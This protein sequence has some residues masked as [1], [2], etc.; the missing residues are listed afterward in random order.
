MAK[1]LEKLQK[2]IIQKQEL[3]NNAKEIL[4][5]E[6]IGID[7]VIDEIID[8]LSSWFL[9]PDL[10]EKPIV[11]NLW[12]L[13]GV[14]KSALVNRL[15]PLL[16]LE[17]K[18]YRFDLGDSDNKDLAVKRQLE[19]IY[20]NVNGYPIMIALDEFQHARTIDEAGKEIDK[21]ASRIVW[22]L[23]DSG[24]FQISRCNHQFA[25]LF[26]LAIKLRYF[27]RIGV[28]VSKGK[29]TSKKEYFIKEMEL[30]QEYERFH[31]VEVKLDMNN[32]FFVPTSFHDDLYSLAKE[33]FDSPFDVKTG[34]SKL[35]GYETLQYLDN[36]FQFANSPKTVDCSKAL[37][38]VLGNLD[39]AYTMSHVYI[40]MKLTHLI[41]PN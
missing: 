24:K 8:S 22:Q 39:E 37:I 23:L 28:R 17:E 19:E 15:A 18:Y 32:I 33:K 3:L 35:N 26:D 20:E 12:G 27:L 14:G 34:L 9:F 6:F 40:L 25:E 41:S 1:Q 30:E 29:V 16:Q 11:V 31:R 38:F 2:T 4:K 7:R 5:K 36:I 21:P 10:Q 13:T